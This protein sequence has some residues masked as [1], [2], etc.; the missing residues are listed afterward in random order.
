MSRSF[1]HYLH[2]FLPCTFCKFSK[3]NQFFN[4]AYIAFR[5]TFVNLFWK[6]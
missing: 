5:I 2:I 4:L 6:G 3:T 1:Y